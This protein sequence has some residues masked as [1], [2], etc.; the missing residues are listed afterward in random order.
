M[1]I[2]RGVKQSSNQLISKERASFFLDQEVNE[3]QIPFA[4]VG[5]G[6]DVG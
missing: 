3:W 4:E 5:E 6:R 2:L 1:Y